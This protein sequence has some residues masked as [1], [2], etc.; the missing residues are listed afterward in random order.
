MAQFILRLLKFLDRESRLEPDSM[1]T[2]VDGVE[3]SACS[4]SSVK[5]SCS[6][7]AAAAVFQNLVLMP[8]INL[9]LGRG[10]CRG[11]ALGV[12]LVEL[13]G[14]VGGVPL[15]AAG[16]RVSR[17]PFIARLSPYSYRRSGSFLQ[18]FLQAVYFRSD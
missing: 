3:I 5:S 16:A 9:L 17:R 2:S 15:R 11:A 10:W 4:S 1:K 14:V 13:S 8:L 18:H 6:S 7:S 12:V